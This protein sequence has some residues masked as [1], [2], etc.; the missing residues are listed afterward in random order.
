MFKFH[1]NYISS[2]IGQN[3]SKIT[4]NSTK[5]YL[6]DYYYNNYR[7]LNWWPKIYSK[8]LPNSDGILYVSAIAINFLIIS[9]SSVELRF[10][11]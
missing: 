10:S 6:D 1:I 9:E 3:P 2:I 11:V 5:K 8:R 7:S 4:N